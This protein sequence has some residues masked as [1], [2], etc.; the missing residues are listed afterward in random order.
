MDEMKTE[1][2]SRRAGVD[3][4]SEND[5]EPNVVG[6]VR[7]KIETLS[8]QARLIKMGKDMITEFADVFALIPHVNRLPDEVHCWVKLK[9]AAQS[10]KT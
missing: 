10:I 8:A 6:A 4:R 7:M 1:C 3:A 5:R 2:A 9:D